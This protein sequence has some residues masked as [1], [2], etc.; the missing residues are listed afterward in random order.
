MDMEDILYKMDLTCVYS[1]GVILP[2]NNGYYHVYLIVNKDKYYVGLSKN[3]HSRI[4]NGHIKK[5]TNNINDYDTKVYILEKL[6]Y[7]KDM[8]DMEYIWIIWFCL[9]TDCINITKGSYKIRAGIINNTNSCI[10]TNYKCFCDYEYI[11]GIKLLSRVDLGNMI[12]E[13]EYFGAEGS[14]R[15]VW[16]NLRMSS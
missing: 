13:V 15:L 1:D 4:K 16:V 8:R 3:L 2:F 10:N 14:R 12:S 9:N 5:N 7:E 11:T 6:I